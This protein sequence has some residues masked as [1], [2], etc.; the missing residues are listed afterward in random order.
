MG[1]LR[2]RWTRA[3]ALLVVGAVLV[4]LPATAAAKPA[5]KKIVGAFY[6]ETNGNPNKLLVFARYNDGT[7]KQLKDRK[8][9]LTG[10]QGGHQGQPIN[11]MAPPPVCTGAGSQPGCPALDSQDAI[12]ESPNRKLLFAVN[13]GSN[14]VSS[15][16]ITK[17]G[18]K[19]VMQV[20]SG[21]KFPDS[22]SVHGNLLY[23]LNAN[24]LNI[25][26]IKFTSSGG[27]T[28]IGTQSLNP[29]S[30]APG[31]PRDIHFD[32]TGKWLVVAKLANPMAISPNNTLDVFPVHSDGTAGPPVSS[33]SIDVVPFSIG[34]DAGDHVLVTTVGNPFAFKPGKLASY[35][36]GPTGVLTP[37]AS[38]TT[39]GY[40]P[41]WDVETHNRHYGYI[42]NADIVGPA[43]PSV[44][45]FHLF[46]NGHFK[47]LGHTRRVGQEPLNTDITLSPDDKYL[48]VVA[49]IDDRAYVGVNISHI[50]V[51][52]IGADHRPR[53]IQVT[54]NTLQQGLTGSATT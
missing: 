54:P 34:F 8:A 4:A 43:A 7:I 44:S 13:A 50:D 52:K 2:F 5:K 3:A 27:M 42:V 48:Y 12:R 24:S 22:L 30:T 47:Y 46:G 29:N 19:L 40:A 23:V 49:G 51:F 14:T 32:N 33:N 6:T 10:G 31:S 1:R 9:F 53:L 37:V 28:P 11:V 16:K 21:G 45:S 39:V 36:I 41:C 17:N 20:T 38:V 25:E 15:F 26:G 18:P 35:S